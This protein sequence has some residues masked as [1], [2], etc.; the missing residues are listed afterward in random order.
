MSTP[1]VIKGSCLCAQIQYE[2]TGDVLNA[3]MCHCNDCRK[4]S[5]SAFVTNSIYLKEQLRILSGEHL[6]K[7]FDKE[8][9]AGNVLSRSFCSNCGSP[10]FITSKNHPGAQVVSVGSMDFA[11]GKN[12]W[13]PRDEYYSHRRAEWFPE[14]TCT[15]KV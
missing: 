7:T 13:Q 12:E 14:L 10:L 4:V 3:T 9:D 5:G 2:A 6:L 8:T 15:R 11:S 1:K